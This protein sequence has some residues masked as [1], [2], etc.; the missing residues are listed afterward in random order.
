MIKKVLIFAVAGTLVFAVGASL[1]N[2][3]MHPS[4][5]AAAAPAASAGLQPQFSGQGQAQVAAQVAA[6]ASGTQGRGQGNGSRR[7]ANNPAPRNNLT[8]WTVYHGTVTAVAAPGFT[9][10]TDDGQTITVELGNQNYLAELGLV[11][12][13]GDQVTVKGFV[14]VN[15]GF[16]AGEITLDATGQTFTLR[17]E[18]GR[19]QWAGGPKH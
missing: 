17:D 7:S 11:L 12:N 13:V 3:A 14:D 5:A 1:Y 15:G 16:A 6:P 10:L 8:E 9:M 19:P 2:L 18:I 4:P